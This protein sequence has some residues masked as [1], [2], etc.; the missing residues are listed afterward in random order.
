M[1]E[2][3]FDELAELVRIPSVSADPGRAADVADA[4]DWLAGFVRRAGGTAEVVPTDTQPLI[5]GDLPA[6]NGAAHSSQATV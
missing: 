5:I 2:P 3:W 1:A 4:A 6:S